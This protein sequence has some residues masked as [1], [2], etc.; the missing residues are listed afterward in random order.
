[1]LII[2]KEFDVFKLYKLESTLFK[3]F[4]LS[5]SFNLNLYGIEEHIF[6]LNSSGIFQ[7]IDFS[8]AVKLARKFKIYF[9]DS[10]GNKYWFDD[11]DKGNEI[12][13]IIYEK[14]FPGKLI[15]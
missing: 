12:F 7:G 4:F 6:K 13:L 14:V 8:E 5:K 10:N 15:Q 11:T 3:I 2:S 1:M 9:E